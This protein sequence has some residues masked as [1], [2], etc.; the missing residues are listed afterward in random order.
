MACNGLKIG[1][2]HLF[3]HPKLQILKWRSGTC[4]ARSLPPPLGFWL[5]LDVVVPHTHR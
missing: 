1:S 5:I 2:F 4:D 3:N